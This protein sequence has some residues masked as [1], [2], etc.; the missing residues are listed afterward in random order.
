MGTGCRRLSELRICYLMGMF[1]GHKISI[2]IEK[3]H[4]SVRKIEC[5]ILAVSLL[6]TLETKN[7]IIRKV[8]KDHNIE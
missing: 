1:H 6:R 4:G 3:M 2:N 8:H 5:G 7:C